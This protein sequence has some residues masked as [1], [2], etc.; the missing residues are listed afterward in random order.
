MK[1]QNVFDMTP[2]EIQHSYERLM[3]GAS[4]SIFQ[5]SKISDSDSIG[6]F[7]RATKFKDTEI[8]YSDSTSS[9]FA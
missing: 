6:H 1:Q 5:L 2:E 9:R 3:E 7:V 4:E 8:C